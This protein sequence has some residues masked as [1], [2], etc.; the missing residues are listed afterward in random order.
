MAKQI[1]HPLQSDE[2]HAEQIRKTICAS[3][4]VLKL[5]R[6]DTFLGRQTHE[7]FPSEQSDDAQREQRRKPR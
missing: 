3:W 5:P 6:P 4:E 7:P 1:H 2:K